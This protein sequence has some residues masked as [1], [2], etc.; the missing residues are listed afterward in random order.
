MAG[1]YR[2]KPVGRKP[3]AKKRKFVRKKKPMYKPKKPISLGTEVYQ[4]RLATQTDTISAHSGSESLGPKNS[5]IVLPSWFNSA[6]TCVDS[7]GATYTVQGNWVKPCYSFTSK[8]RISF[9]NIANHADNKAGLN[10]RCYHGVLNLTEN[11]LTDNSAPLS[12]AAFQTTCLLACKEELFNSNLTA[13]PLDYEKRNRNVRVLGSFDV[14]PDRRRMI[15]MDVKEDSTSG[16][17]ESINVPP[18]KTYTIRHMCPKMK[19]RVEKAQ[20][21]SFPCPSNLWIPWVMIA[22][23]QLTTNSGH[24]DLEYSSRMYFT[25]N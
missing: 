4:M 14:V 5:L 12:Q 7:E 11:K 23:P 13:D 24:F 16:E 17:L 19:T 8:L 20:D 6:S 22:S 25:D 10:L 2:R 9:A 18:P 3:P 15:R 1:K 21:H